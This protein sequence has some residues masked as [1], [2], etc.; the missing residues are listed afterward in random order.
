LR[1]QRVNFESLSKEQ[2][3]QMISGLVE[4]KLLTN[5]AYKSDIPNQ[6]EYKK[7]LEK[8]K[9]TLAFQFWIRDFSKSI[10]VSDKDVQK[11]YNENKAQLK[12]PAQLKASHIL[13]KTK[14]EADAIIAD[15]SKSS[16]LKKS[17]TKTAQE[18]STGPSGAN[19][20]ELGWFTADKMV[21]E[22]S[23]AALKLN[24]GAITK[25][26]VQT[27]YGFHII[28]L[29]DKKK[30]ATLEFAKIKDRLKQDLLQKKFTDAVKKKAEALKKHAKIEYK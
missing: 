5:E 19:G 30:P 29:D 3:K 22:F 15:L 8:F 23:S 4:Q 12:S 27:Q 6:K 21:P 2:Q 25:T 20:G 13:V 14:K 7:E 1:D 26:P 28:Y 16:D 17:F 11:F 24:V 18:K 9:K 10:T